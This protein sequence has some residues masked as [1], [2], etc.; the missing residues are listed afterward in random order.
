MTDE[1]IEK[2]AIAIFAAQTNW[3]TPNPD[4]RQIM[5]WWDAQPDMV[6]DATRRLAR[7]ALESQTGEP[8]PLEWA[9]ADMETLDGWTVEAVTREG[10][11]VRGRTIGFH[12][13]LDQ[14]IIEGVY[15]S[16]L[17]RLPGERWRLAPSW[18]TVTFF[19]KEENRS[20]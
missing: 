18:K 2:A 6:K 13:S 19:V 12:G 7:A 8:D 4:N 3:A 11:L 9:D 14:I 17:M 16:L 15:R 20:C 5:E 1:R 10:T